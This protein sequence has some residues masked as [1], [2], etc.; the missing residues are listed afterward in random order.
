MSNRLTRTS[1]AAAVVAVLAGGA[2][3]LS[4]PHEGI[5]HA[6]PVGALDVV[7][8]ASPVMVSG[9]DFSPIVERYG[10]AVVNISTTGRAQK[11]S[12]DDEPGLAPDDPI[13]QF[14]QQF[15]Q[16]FGPQ[17][18]RGR[19]PR[20]APLVRGEG[21][22]FI[23]SP[24]GL[25]LTNAHVVDG[26]QVVTVRLTDRREFAAK[27]LGVDKQTDVAVLRIDAKDLPVVRLGDPAATK[28]GEPVVAIGS[29]FGFENSVTSGIV[30]AKARALPDDN[31][32]PFIQTD[33]A[34]NPGNSGGPLFNARGEVIGINSQIYT[35][36]GGYQG[37]S[38]AIPIDVATK[39]QAQLVAHGKV[40][41]ARLGVQIQDVNQALADAFGLA[42]PMG[43]LVSAV[44]PGGPAD[45][46][47]LQSGDVIVAV[48]D[49]PIGHSFDLPALVSEQ[50][51]GSTLK[52]DVIRK[53]DRKT[54]TATLGEMKGTQVAKA[55]G[56]E[57][58]E[59]RLGLAVRPL[60]PDEKQASGLPGGLVVQQAS[61]AAAQAGLQPGDVV[62]AC[63]GTSVSSVEQLRALVAQAKKHVA[64]LIQ[65]DDAKIFVPVDL[66]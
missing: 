45:K 18:R 20:G 56:H 36:S 42:K 23:V 5:A 9:M 65:R 6:A 57:V 51:P 37:L 33:V 28:V 43:A 3:Q 55:G 52:L 30:S 34:V 1:I 41:R 46:A 49:Q 13:L 53:G 7:T 66:G 19:P 26:A 64:L 25:I 15:G 44:E 21:S 61:G 4:T 48:G 14:F 31:Y 27:V 11:T 22:G 24:D 32:V 50:K 8:G 2:W 29:P 47:G 35:R 16:Q 17:L 39:V 63:N 62:L 54:L 10:P 59:G 38:F 40:T 58:D 12:D 60:Q